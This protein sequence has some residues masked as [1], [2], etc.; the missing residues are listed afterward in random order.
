MNFSGISCNRFLYTL[1]TVLIYCSSLVQLSAREVPEL[2][3]MVMDQADMIDPETEQRILNMLQSHSQ[4]T[5][6]QIVVLTID[7]LDGDVLEQYSLKVAETWQLGQKGKDNGVLFLISKNDRKLRI[8]VGYGLEGVL[9]DAHSSRIIRNL[10]VPEFKKEN[11]S[12][13]IE[14]GV[15]GILDRLQSPVAVEDR[16]SVARAMAAA[17]SDSGESVWD[18]ITGYLATAIGIG[19]FGLFAVFFLRIMYF[20]EGFTGWLFLLVFSIVPALLVM[21]TFF[22]N[23]SSFQYVGLI[24]TYIFQ[25]GLRLFFIHTKPGKKLSEK[26]SVD[27]SSSGGSYSSGSGSSY[28]SSSYSSSSSFSGGGGSFGGGGA[29]GSW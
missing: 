25:I 13:G 26:Y 24:L 11:Y 6:D 5:T 9:T 27:L 8:E 16:E 20:N 19:I 22:G 15:L 29:S 12:E 1:I 17:D 28:S 10:V 7:S 2:T 4:E 21:V 23:D 14:N 18:K 3:G